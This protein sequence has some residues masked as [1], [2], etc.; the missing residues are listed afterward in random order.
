M[1]NQGGTGIIPSVD[2]ICRYCEEY[3]EQ[4]CPFLSCLVVV[5]QVW[6]S[7]LGWESVY[8]QTHQFPVKPIS[9]GVFSDRDEEIVC[10]CSK[11]WVIFDK[12]QVWVK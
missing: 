8:G 5:K 12:F 4:S 10:T 2:V 1:N 6:D 9:H 7:Q 3:T 11:R